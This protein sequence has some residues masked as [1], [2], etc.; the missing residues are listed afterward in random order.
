MGQN[1]DFAKSCAASVGK[2]P[3]MWVEARFTHSVGTFPCMW[4]NP[5]RTEKP[6]VPFYYD[7]CSRPV[8]NA[9]GGATARSDECGRICHHRDNPY[10]T[11]D[12]KN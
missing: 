11:D 7:D 3:G 10:S 5:V 12:D 2:N 1:S 9:H 4:E 6:V 8:V